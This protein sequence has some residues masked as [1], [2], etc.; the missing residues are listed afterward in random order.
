MQVLSGRS[1]DVHR[2][3]MI[4]TEKMLTVRIMMFIRL[5]AAMMPMTMT[6]TRQNCQ[7]LCGE[8]FVA[9]SVRREIL[10]T[11]DVDIRM[12]AMIVMI[13][14]VLVTIMITVLVLL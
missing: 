3:E 8:K 6:K 7:S 12:T 11:V 5:F 4:M 2:L 14:M 1:V 13:T 9:D 10:M